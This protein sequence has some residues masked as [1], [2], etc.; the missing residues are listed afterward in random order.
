MLD[1]L[2][3]LILPR[4]CTLCESDIDPTYHITAAIDKVLCNSCKASLSSMQKNQK[5]FNNETYFDVDTY[6][7]EHFNL[8]EMN[9]LWHDLLHNWKFENQRDIMN[10]FKYFMENTLADIRAKEIDYIVCVNSGKSIYKTRRFQPCLDI[11]RYLSEELNVPYGANIYKIKEYKQSLNSQ[12][13][14]FLAVH[15]SMEVRFDEVPKS[16]LLFD[17]VLTTGATL[18]EAAHTLKNAGVKYIFAFSL[19]RQKLNKKQEEFDV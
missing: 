18:N 13:E 19:L 14:R 12:Y 6:F 4:K 11:C 9:G 8:I 16:C 10:V 15:K 5:T 7:D 2:V 1:S 17:D 3:E